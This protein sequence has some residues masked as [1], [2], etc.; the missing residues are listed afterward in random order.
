M[1]VEGDVLLEMFEKC[2]GNVVGT[3]VEL[4]VSVATV[5]ASLKK[6]KIKF[7]VPNNIYFALKEV[8]FSPE[9]KSMLVGSLF[10]NGF[11][12]KGNRARYARFEER[13]SLEQLPL[14][15][16][17]FNKLLPF[18]SSDKF[19]VGEKVC[20]ETCSHPFLS[21]LLESSAGYLY[22]LVDE[23][24][25]VTWL[26]F[27]G[28]LDGFEYSVSKEDPG[29]LNFFSA[30]IKC[31]FDYECILNENILSITA[32]DNRVLTLINKIFPKYKNYQI[33]QFS[34]N[35]KRLLNIK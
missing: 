15:K 23:V 17:K 28:K 21:R 33:P 34:T 1:I 30:A 18:V 7:E 8:D 12:L 20:L 9:Q 4:N 11:V 26:M 5:M 32:T 22:S 3:A 24:A 10:G 2:G 6:A 31:L 35:T 14:M 29:T 13:S 27:Y 25:V 19:V 16:L